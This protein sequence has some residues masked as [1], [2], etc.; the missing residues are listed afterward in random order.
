MT[1]DRRLLVGGWAALLTAVL[2]PVEFVV[3]FVVARDPDPLGTPAFVAV[4]TLRVGTAL[5]AMVG[6]DRLFRSISPGAAPVVLVVGCAGAV[7]G[8]LGGAAELLGIDTP[9]LDIPVV[10]T[11]N[12]LV[13]AWFIGGGAILMRQGGGLARI[14]WTAELGGLGMILTAIAIAIPFAG[15]IGVTGTSLNDWYRILGLFVVVYLVRIW[16]Y[17]VGGRLPG[18]GIL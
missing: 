12:I 14:G 16:R 10:L 9:A 15:P 7:I 5:L 13:G 4:E 6:L 11:T 2:V 8:I 17:V 18:P 1:P 3:L